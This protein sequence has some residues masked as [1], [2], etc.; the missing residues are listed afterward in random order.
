MTAAGGKHRD[1]PLGDVL[2]FQRTAC[3][4]AG[5]HLYARILAVM[6]A[7]VAA[8]GTCLD[9][10]GPHAANA[11]ADAV[12]LRLLA[13]VHALVLSGRA[14]GLAA[15]Y[16]SAGGSDEVTDD[17]LG[18]RFLAVLLDHRDEL[19][20]AMHRGVQT[21]EVGRAAALLGAFH[22]VSLRTGLPLR[23]LEVGTSAGLLLRWDRYRYEATGPGGSRWG[24]GPTG[25]ATFRDV[26]VGEI[27]RLDPSLSVAERAGCDISPIDVLTDEGADRLRSFLWPD[28]VERRIRLDAA[29]AAARLEPAA[30]DRADAADWV[31]ARLAEAA[32]GT[33]T[34]VHHSIVLQYLPRDTFR[35]MRA[36]IEEAGSRA[37]PSAPIHWLRMEPAGDHADVRLRSWPGD[38]DELVATAGFHGPPVRWLGAPATG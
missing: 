3:D 4:E 28:Q 36:A 27:P 35:R 9:L 2:A 32:P 30:I 17:E 37:T 16:P 19:A 18:R 31:T 29:I 13:G 34:V 11:M 33:A 25:G 14:P 20:E 22:L 7:D 10:L 1:L 6:E 15:V 8:G 21:N 38:T 12:P 26:F 24:W 23:Q 5:S